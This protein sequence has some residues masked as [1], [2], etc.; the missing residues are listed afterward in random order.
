MCE[1]VAQK[2]D[3]IHDGLAVLCLSG[4]ADSRVIVSETLQ[5][6]RGIRVT[7]VQ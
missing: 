7:L 2:Q 6:L 1:G 3:E 5:V 4:A